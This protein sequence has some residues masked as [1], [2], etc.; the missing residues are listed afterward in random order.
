MARTKPA[1]KTRGKKK[2][3]GKKGEPAVEKVRPRLF[4]VSPEDIAPAL[5]Y[6]TLA[7][8]LRSGDAACLL[9]RGKDSVS[10]RARMEAV[11]SLAHAHNLAVLLH[12]APELAVE[13]GADGVQIQADLARYREVRS[14]VGDGRIVGVFCGQSRHAAMELGEAGA[15]YV[16]F[17]ETYPPAAVSDE[18]E[19]G[20]D[21]PEFSLLGWWAEVFEVPCVAFAPNEEAAVRRHAGLGVEFIRPA[22]EMW[23]SA[24]AASEIMSRCNAVIDEVSRDE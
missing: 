7:A 18:Q 19:S 5:L 12:D 13:L 4:L 21:D 24:R 22:D 16:A 15:E 9:V 8:A 23:N 17:D 3:R 1:G 6:E 2:H 10:I 11:Q 14:I 20:E